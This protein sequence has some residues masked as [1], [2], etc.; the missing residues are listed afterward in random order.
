[1][2]EIFDDI[3]SDIT[4]K[5]FKLLAVFFLHKITIAFKFGKNCIFNEF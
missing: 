5:T 2:K 3:L 4:N 1:M